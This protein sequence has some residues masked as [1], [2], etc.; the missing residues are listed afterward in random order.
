MSDNQYEATEVRE[1]LNRIKENT[2]VLEEIEGN[3]TLEEKMR[4][5]V[6]EGSMMSTEG[7]L[8]V[9]LNLLVKERLSGSRVQNVDAIFNLGLLLGSALERDVPANSEEEDEWRDG[10]FTLPDEV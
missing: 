1:M 10:E 9:E 2:Q 7:T 6:E 4:Q 8:E 3:D 5:V